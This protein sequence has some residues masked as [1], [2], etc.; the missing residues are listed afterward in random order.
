LLQLQSRFTAMLA[1][2][3]SARFGSK[4]T[5][6]RT[7]SKVSSQSGQASTTATVTLTMSRLVGSTPT[8]SSLAPV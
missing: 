6:A 3:S 4:S 7:A 8:S 1:T 2:I 5:A